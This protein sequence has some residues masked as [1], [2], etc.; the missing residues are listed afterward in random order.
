MDVEFKDVC[1]KI[2]NINIIDKLNMKL[3]SNKVNTIYDISDNGKLIYDLINN[4]ITDYSGNILLGKKNIKKINE[5]LDIGF[6]DINIDNNYIVS[7]YLINKLKKYNY[8]LD[9]L[10][11][12]VNDS[13][14]M[15]GLSST[16][17]Q[18]KVLE[19]SSGEIT[20]LSLASLLSLNPKVIVMYNPTDNLDYVSIKNLIKIIRILKNRFHKTFILVSNNIEFIHKISDNIYLICD[21]NVIKSGNKYDIFTD[22]DIIE[23]YDIKLPSTISFSKKVLDIKNKRLGYRDDINDL[24]KDIYR[25][26]R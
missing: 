7:E 4:N 13:L 25:N 20:L 2:N 16:I 12:H 22:F 18:K 26:A 14:K 10:D 6:L 9:I 21:G 15:V 23:K 19:L 17:L 11:K 5:S 3:I 8:K 1:Y 24:L